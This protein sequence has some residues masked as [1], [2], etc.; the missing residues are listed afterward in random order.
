MQI[1]ERAVLVSV[2][3]ELPN[4][5][6]FNQK[7]IDAQKQ[8]S[9]YKNEAMQDLGLSGHSA[10][11][12]DGEYYDY[13]PN[14]NALESKGTPWWDLETRENEDDTKQ[15]TMTDLDGKDVE[16]VKKQMK[17]GIGDASQP[18]KEIKILVTKN[19]AKI[20][21]QWWDNKYKKLG[22]YT[23]LPWK[24]G[25]QCTSTVMESL[26]KANIIGKG[27]FGTLS[28]QTEITDPEEFYEHFLKNVKHTAGFLL[29]DQIPS[30]LNSIPPNGK[31]APGKVAIEIQIR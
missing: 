30:D 28:Y 26:Y 8:Y 29:N 20:I 14:G 24:D 6:S 4:H 15:Y 5:K 12:I 13:G 2:F 9:S 10:I 11:A 23:A 16:R 19:Q 22:T 1:D 21:K 3:V 17:L 31:P 7:R 25:E 27:F 18:I